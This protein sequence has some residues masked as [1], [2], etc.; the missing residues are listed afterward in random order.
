MIN[1]KM[2]LI[3]PYYGV[4]IHGDMH[5]EL[6]VCDYLNHVYPDISFIYAATIANENQNV[7][8]TVI[9]ANMEKILPKRVLKS[10][11]LFYDIIVVKATAPS[12]KF[13]LE[14]LEALANIYKQGTKIYISGHI[15][16]ILKNYLEKNIP[17]I[18]VAEKPIEN[19]VHNLIYGES[20]NITI[21]DFPT[22]NYQ[23]FKY[24]NLTDVDDNLRGT[25]YMSRGCMAGCSY[26]PYNAYYGKK[27]EYR[28]VNKVIEDVK[29]LASLGIKNIQFRD[30][31]FATNRKMVTEFCEKLITLNMDLTW[32][33]ETRLES[34]NE[35]ILDLM[36]KS[37]MDMIFFGVESS[38]ANTL[39]KYSRPNKNTEKLISLINYLK[40]RNVETCAFYII[41]FPDDTWQ[42]ISDTFN[43]ACKLAT[44]YAKFSIFSP[45]IFN[46]DEFKNITPDIFV[47]FENAIS[48]NVCKNLNKEELEFLLDQLTIMYHSRINSLESSFNFHYIYKKKY[49]N[50][51]DKLKT[52]VLI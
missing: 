14:F 10:L 51:I 8:L 46:S 15:A 38:S 17:Q 3:K 34:L 45:N 42:S 1:V 24:K 21:D 22:P 44:K 48:I 50:F 16:K 40:T 35:E 26:C 6:G 2:L 32:R 33:C 7:D 28:S 4:T 49:I 19:H 39:S 41:G 52:A 25:L 47:P 9:D 18:I 5:G 13:D 27:I 23:L 12:I 37:G 43:F 20:K 30:Q 11:D 36:I 31:Y 29:Y